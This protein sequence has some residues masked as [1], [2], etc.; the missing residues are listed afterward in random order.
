MLMKSGWV[1]R[2]RGIP[3]GAGDTGITL[4]VGES[5]GVDF[6]GA[7]NCLGLEAGRGGGKWHY[8]A[9]VMA[10]TEVL[11]LPISQLAS[12]PHWSDIINAFDGFSRAD[13]KPPA[14]IEEVPDL[15]IMASAEEEIATGIVD[16]ANLLVM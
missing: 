14:T 15:R 9:S 12:D 7:G 3:F 11:E 2:V 8:N 4:G 13:D 1:R 5:I 10:R 16:G 6:L